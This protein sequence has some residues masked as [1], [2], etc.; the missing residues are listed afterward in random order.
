MEKIVDI[1][2]NQYV[3]LCDNFE[4]PMEYHIIEKQ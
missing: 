3:S 2:V 1:T 4:P